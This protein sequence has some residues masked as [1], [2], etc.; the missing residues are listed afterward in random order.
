VTTAACY[1]WFSYSVGSFPAL[2]TGASGERWGTSLQPPETISI[3]YVAAYV[4]MSA[5]I[6][7]REWVRNPELLEHNDGH[8]LVSIKKEEVGS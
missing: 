7:A 3:H 1:Y 6:G 8:L 4:E 5:S 2:V